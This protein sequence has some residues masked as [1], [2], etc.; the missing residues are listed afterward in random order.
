MWAMARF[1]SS[2]RSYLGEFLKIIFNF[3]RPELKGM[4]DQNED[5]QMEVLAEFGSAKTDNLHMNNGGSRLG[6]KGSGDDLGFD[7]VYK[8]PAWMSGGDSRQPLSLP[9]KIMPIGHL[10]WPHLGSE[11]SSQIMQGINKNFC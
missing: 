8:L 3:L 10:N 4:T 11:H 1:V 7:W 5:F 9:Q 6:L 2:G